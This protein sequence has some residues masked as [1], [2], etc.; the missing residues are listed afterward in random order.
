MSTFQATMP[1]RYR[2]AFDERAIGEHAAIVSRRAG[3]PVHVEVWQRLPDGGAVVCVVADD[4][5]GLLS[6]ICASLVVHQMDV[7]AAHVYTRIE[8]E[9]GR[10]EAVDFL[11]L[12]RDAQLPLPVLHADISR[13]RDALASLVTGNTTLEEV[14]RKARPFRPPP[15][16]ASTRVTFDQ[17]TDE[18]LVVLTV[19]TFDRPGLLLAITQALFRAGVQII[20]SD[21]TTRNGRVVDRFTIVELDG[22]PIRPPR[23]GVVQMEV[24]AAIDALARGPH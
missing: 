4:R 7:T 15:P 24:L 9:S 23:R 11:W 20:A 2:A 22:T 21:A 16:G 18:S 8:P 1:E 3:A 19:E 10:A 6:F 5:P 12:R 13:I 14:I 17:S